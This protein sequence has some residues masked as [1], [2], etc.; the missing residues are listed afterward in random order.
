VERVEEEEGGGEGEKGERGRGS[1][2]GGGEGEDERRDENA[3]ARSLKRE[4]VVV[5]EEEVDAEVLGEGGTEEDEAEALGRVLQQKVW[6][7]RKDKSDLEMSELNEAAKGK[8]SK[9]KREPTD[10]NKINPLFN[11]LSKSCRS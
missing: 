10:K 7:R 3:K 8:R 6:L 4:S 1:D 9:V 2:E 11:D 5:E